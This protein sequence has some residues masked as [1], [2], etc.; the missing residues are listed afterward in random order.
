MLLLALKIIA[1]SGSI[2]MFMF[3]SDTSLRLRLEIYSSTQ[4]RKGCP[5][6]VLIT[7]PMYDL[8]SLLHRSQRLVKAC[9]AE[10]GGYL[11]DFIFNAG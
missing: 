1:I 4:T 2:S 6:T 5:A 3:F 11:Q 8:G 10:D 9:H 7:L